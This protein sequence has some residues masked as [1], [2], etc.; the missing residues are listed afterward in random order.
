M[1]DLRRAILRSRSSP[2]RPRFLWFGRTQGSRGHR[3]ISWSNGVDGFSSS[4]ARHCCEPT[5]DGE[6]RLYSSDFADTAPSRN[7]TRASFHRAIGFRP[8]GD[9]W[10]NLQ[11]GSHLFT[12]FSPRRVSF[13]KHRREIVDFM[14]GEIKLS[15]ERNGFVEEEALHYGS[16][17]QRV[18]ERFGEKIRF[19]EGRRMELD[20]LVMKGTSFSS[21]QLERPFA[22][23]VSSIRRGR[24]E[25]AEH[26]FQSRSLYP[27]S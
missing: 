7:G 19:W 18:D 4:A 2:G 26:C 22:S 3:A 1:G 11:P 13:G 10:R 16:L 5:R 21:F 24:R 12:L 17:E 8:S 20:M 15:M 6:R 14:I 23:W 25:D 9:Y 27:K